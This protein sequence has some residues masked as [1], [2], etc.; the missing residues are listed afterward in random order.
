[1]S[2]CLLAALCI[3]NVLFILSYFKNE[4]N[5]P[6][7]NDRLVGHGKTSSSLKLEALQLMFLIPVYMCPLNTEDK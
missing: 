7:I 1:M 6:K 4:K 3:L 5:D 2:V